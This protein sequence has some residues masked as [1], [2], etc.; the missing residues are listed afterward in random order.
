MEQQGQGP[1]GKVEEWATLV[2]E[3]KEGTT[4]G[5]EVEVERPSVERL[6]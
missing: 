1:G 6:R 4:L 5:G 3:V 2:G